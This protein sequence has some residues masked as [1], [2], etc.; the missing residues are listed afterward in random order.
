MDIIR[1][2]TDQTRE[3]KILDLEQGE[4]PGKPTSIAC[5]KCFNLLEEYG[6]GELLHF[7]CHLEHIYSPKNLL[8]EQMTALKIAFWHEFLS[9][10]EKQSWLPYDN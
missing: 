10:K 8:A 2:S 4:K 5:P 9:L 7:R 1:D 6:E 3:Q